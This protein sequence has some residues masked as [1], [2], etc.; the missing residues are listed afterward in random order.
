MF[1]GPVPSMLQEFIAGEV[2]LLNTLF[3]KSLHH[4]GFSRYRGVVGSGYPTSILAFHA[5]ASHQNILDGVVEHVTH[6]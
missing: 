4:L 1:V 3:S 2:M 5:G 6:V